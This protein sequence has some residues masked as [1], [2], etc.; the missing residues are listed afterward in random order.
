[1]GIYTRRV[2]GQRLGKHVPAAT[3]THAMEK[4]NGVLPKRS[5]PRSYIVENRNQVPELIR[6]VSS[7]FCKGLEHGSRGIAIVRSRYQKTSSSRLEKT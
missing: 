6:V 1:M 2:S 7:Q 4:K 3:V 5:V